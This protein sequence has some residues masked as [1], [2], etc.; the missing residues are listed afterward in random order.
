MKNLSKIKSSSEQAVTL[1]RKAIISGDIKPGEKLR[2][3]EI[4]EA[5]GVSRSPIREAFRVLES[6]GLVQLEANKGATVT[7]LTEKDLYEIYDLRILIELH[8]LQLSWEYI[9]QNEIDKVDNIIIQME[10][11]LDAKDY[12][13]YLKVSHE[14]HEFILNNCKND[15]LLKMFNILKNNI[16][17]IQIL[18]NP[19]PKYSK[20]S[21]QEHKKVLSAIKDRDLEKATHYL[22]EHLRAGYQRARKYLKLLS[23]EERISN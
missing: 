15:R 3:T 14:F 5:L 17:T 22:K 11:H 8:G 20:D 21:M 2:E 9:T 18:A 6:E 10:K 19:Y 23:L 1:L 7:K 4:S 16:F 12:D 13:R